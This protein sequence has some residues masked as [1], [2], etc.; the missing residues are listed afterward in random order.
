MADFSETERFQVGIAMHFCG[1]LTDLALGACLRQHAAFAFCPCCYGKVALNVV[2]VQ[3]A[4]G[5]E[6]GLFVWLVGWLVGWLVVFAPTHTTHACFFF[7]FLS[8]R[9]GRAAKV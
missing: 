3:P 8:N 7:S 1:M 6:Q 5:Q 9:R 2:E 4:K